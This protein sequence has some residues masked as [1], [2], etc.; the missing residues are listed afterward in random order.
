VDQLVTE[1]MSNLRPQQTSATMNVP[2][3]AAASTF[4]WSILLGTTALVG[5]ALRLFRLDSQSVWY[6]EVFALSVSRMPFAQMHKALIQDLVHPPLHYYALHGWFRAFGFGVFQARLLSALFGTLA[7]VMIYVLADYLFDRRAA[8]LSAVLLAFSQLAIMYSQEARPYAQFSLLYICCAYLLLRALRE[9]RL[10]I[11]CGFLCLACLLIY[12]HYYGFLAI[13]SFLAFGFVLRKEYSLSRLWLWGGIAVLTLGYLPWLANGVVREAVHGDKVQRLSMMARVAATPVHWFTLATAVNV[14]NN[15][16]PSG[17]LVSSP[18]WTFVVGGL[19]FCLPAALALLPLADRRNK[20]TNEIRERENLLY[21]VLLFAVPIGLAL[22][23]GF[24]FGTYDVKYV[25]FCSAPY[26]IL[27]AR[28]LSL[29]DSSSSR[30]VMVFL[31]LTYSMLSLRANYFI[32]YKEDYKQALASVAHDYRPSDCTV[33]APSWEQRQ[34]QWAWSIYES[35]QPDLHAM[36]LNLVTSNTGACERVW[37]I[38]VL[39]KRN[40]TAVRAA[41]SAQRQLALSYFEHERRNFFWVDVD[42]YTAAGAKLEAEMKA[43]STP[44]SK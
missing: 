29:G 25:A 35:K 10:A 14:F 42:L 3:Q 7:I 2:V 8:I 37:L 28:G 36:P 18:W 24:L 33:V 40:P 41:E 20:K 34:A 38:S 44:A 5:F 9:K 6:D 12:T 43:N 32:P 22:V 11:W 26:Y 39:D 30:R 27:V 13:A 16:H 23:A 19:L 17:L 21:L 1:S 31:I 15:G 4:V